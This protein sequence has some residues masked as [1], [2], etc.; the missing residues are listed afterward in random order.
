ME[1]RD[2]KYEQDNIGYDQQYPEGGIKCKNYELCE[3]ILSPDWWEKF[4]NYLCMTC[5]SWYKNG[6]G[7]NEL[8]FK[9]TNEE[10]IICS[11]MCSRQVKFPANCIHW[12]CIPC[13]QNILFYNETRYHLSPVHFGCPSCPNGCINP[14]KG[15]QCNCKEYDE[16]IEQW[17]KENP[18]EYNEYLENQEL[19]INS[20]DKN[21]SFSSCICPLCRAKY[22]RNK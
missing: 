17:G 5:G 15:K 4:Q 11:E 8:E 12:F 6:F 22:E 1:N 3:H 19:S 18:N 16:I 9:S 10:C 21:S 2:L 13:S 20:S 7:W 14:V